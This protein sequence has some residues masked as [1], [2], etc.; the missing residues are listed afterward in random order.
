MSDI[1]WQAV[2]WVCTDSSVRLRLNSDEK[3]AAI[4]R[5]LPRM[6]DNQDHTL[7]ANK[8]S[9]ADVA[10]RMVTTE[11]SIERYKAEL[12][13]ATEMRCRVC[14]QQVLAI[15]GRVSPHPDSRG[16]ETCLMS[17]GETLRGLAAIRPDLY[18]WLEEVSA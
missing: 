2:E 7:Y 1:D 8:L 9:S 6:L 16:T 13:H 17:G 15:N 4:R 14:H 11:R 3:R 12:A 10:R 5:L 18:Q